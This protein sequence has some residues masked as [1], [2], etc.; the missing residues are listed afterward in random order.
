MKKSELNKLSG[1]YALTCPHSGKVRY[2]G[3]SKNILKRYYGHK[4]SHGKLPVNRW[5]AKLKG[6][7]LSPGIILLENHP[8]PEKV[9]AK[10]IKEFRSKGQADLN[11]HDGGAGLAMSGNGRCEEVWSVE[12]VAGPF[13]LLVRALWRFQNIQAGKKA[14]KFWKDKWN[15]CENEID[16]V[17]V[18]MNMYQVIQ[19]LGTDDLRVKVEKWAIAAAPQINKK[20]PARVTLEYNDGIEV[21]P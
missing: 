3:R 18:C 5:C 17:N 13:S 11:L 20:Y 14:M 9:E 16:R 4:G 19:S 21:T 6:S 2:V 8:E 7:G 1:I 15:S 10:W 12:G